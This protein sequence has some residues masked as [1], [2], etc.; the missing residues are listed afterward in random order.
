MQKKHHP[1]WLPVSASWVHLTKRLK[2]KL[3]VNIHSHMSNH[4]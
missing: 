3:I 2:I 1:K 4:V